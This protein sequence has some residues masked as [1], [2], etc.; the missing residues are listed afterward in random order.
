MFLRRPLEPATRISPKRRLDK[1]CAPW[2]LGYQMAPAKESIIAR[3][4]GESWNYR[5]SER[6]NPK[7][8]TRS[9]KQT[10]STKQ[11]MIKTTTLLAV[12]GLGPPEP[13]AW[14][15]ISR[16]IDVRPLTPSLSPSGL[17][18]A[19]RGH[20]CQSLSILPELEWG[21]VGAGVI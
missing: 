21:M 12:L 9:P 15:G 2:E 3:G 19:A 18:L 8:E 20:S 6:G 4:L 5:H 11:G 10:P 13:H 16:G 17:C 1:I 14:I 7:S